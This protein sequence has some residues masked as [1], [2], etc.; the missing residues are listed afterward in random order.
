MKTNK[1]YLSPD[2]EQAFGQEFY[3]VNNDA[4]G[5]PRYVTHYLAF[6]DDY[7]TAKKIANSLGFSVYRARWFGGGF[8]GT[9]YNL[10]NT[11]EQIIDKK[12]RARF[13]RSFKI[14]AVE[15]ALSRTDVTSSK[16][17]G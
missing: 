10:E 17:L 3:R 7:A 1:C 13:T 2:L 9:S 14:Q 4:N 12:M 16:A 5:N 11:V 6:G 8:V 15:K